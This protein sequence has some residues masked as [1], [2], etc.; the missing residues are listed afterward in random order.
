MNSPSTHAKGLIITLA[1]VVVLTPDGLL[2]R[3]VSTDQWTLLFWRGLLMGL[4]ILMGLA[5]WHRGDLSAR[6]RAIGPLGL[7]ISLHFAAGALLFVT[8]ISHTSVANTLFIMSTTPLFTAIMAR[9]FLGEP[10]SSRTWLAISLA[11]VGIAVIVLGSL[12]QGSLWGDLAAFATAIVMASSFV[13]VRRAR[14]QS[15]VPAMA[16]G[17]FVT[18]LCALPFGAVPAAVSSTD[19]IYLVLM[20][21]IVLPISFSLITLGPRYI[22]APEAS[23][24][25]LLEAVLGPFWVWLVLDEHPGTAAIIGGAI[26]I[27]TL[28]AHS[29]SALKNSGRPEAAAAG[30]S[31][32]KVLSKAPRGCRAGYPAR[33]R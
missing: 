10:V 2:I 25:F 8:A 32:A 17:G 11:V 31:A 6:F 20:G 9:L 13:L 21:V 27:V 19:L 29:V 5:L 4:A 26:V 16:L 12:D 28:A 33:T 23:L 30:A 22:P 3:L 18:A 15:M 14:A 7:W 1:G 24:I